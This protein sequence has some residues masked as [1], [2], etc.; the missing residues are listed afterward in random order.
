MGKTAKKETERKTV[1]TG[2]A[3][4]AYNTL[5]GLRIMKLDKGDMFAVLRAA[6]TLK[7]VAESFDGFLRDARERLKPEGWDSVSERIARFDTLPDEEK[8]ELNRIAQAYQNDVDECVRTEMDKEAD[9]TGIARISEDA[10]ATIAS[11]NDSLD[12]QSLMLL[13]SVCGE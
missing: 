6:N 7:P 9:I 5:K 8:R 11:D 12:V 13:Q 10:L 3:V 1:R 4:A 2:D